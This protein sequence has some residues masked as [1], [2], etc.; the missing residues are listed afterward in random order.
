MKGRT[1]SIA[2]I[3]LFAIVG[4]VHRS[5]EAAILAAFGPLPNSMGSDDATPVYVVFADEKSARV[6]KQLGKQPGVV[7]APPGTPATCGTMTP[8]SSSSAYVFRASVGYVHGDSAI[9]SLART[10]FLGMNSVTASDNYLFL[11]H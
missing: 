2:G 3:A 11:K 9:A 7:L 6:F 1:W 4:C 8:R 10:C 5:P